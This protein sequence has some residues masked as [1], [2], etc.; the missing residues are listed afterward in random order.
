[1]PTPIARLRIARL[2]H[3]PSEALPAALEEAAGLVS[4]AQVRRWLCRIVPEYRPSRV[5]PG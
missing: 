2:E 5:P 4:D 1:M 3:R